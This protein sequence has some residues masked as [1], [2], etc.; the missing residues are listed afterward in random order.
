MPWMIFKLRQRPPS[1]VR[2]GLSGVLIMTNALDRFF[3]FCS[4]RLGYGVVG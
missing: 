1:V 2:E 3:I 4:N